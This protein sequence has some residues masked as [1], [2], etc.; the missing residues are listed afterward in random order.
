MDSNEDEFEK[1][2]KSYTPII[3]S[4]TTPIQELNSPPSPTKPAFPNPLSNPME[5][6]NIL[7]ATNDPYVD[8]PVINQP[9][10]MTGDITTDL[11]T[12]TRS[13]PQVDEY[14]DIQSEELD[15]FVIKAEIVNCTVKLTKDQGSLLKDLINEIYPHTFPH[16][17]TKVGISTPNFYNTVNGER[18]CSLEFLN[19]LL[20]GVGYLATM[21][22]LE[23]LIQEV[24]IAEI[25]HSHETS[26]S[27][28]SESDL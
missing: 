4:S 10:F 22:S 16:Y 26:E 12:P 3:I 6:A 20:S 11:H 5:I 23:V 25:K 21:S 8:E 14:G 19:K 28:V 9:K 7:R 15:A 17:C 27:G 18:P 1:L 24:E 2:V 13:V